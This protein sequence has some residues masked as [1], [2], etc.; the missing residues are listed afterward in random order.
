MTTLYVAINKDSR[1]IFFRF[2]FQ[3]YTKFWNAGE[4]MTVV[5]CVISSLWWFIFCPSF[6]YFIQTTKQKV[7]SSWLLLKHRT[8]TI[9][10]REQKSQNNREQRSEQYQF[11]SNVRG[12]RCRSCRWN[13]GGLKTV[14]FAQLL[15]LSC[16]VDVWRIT[17]GHVADDGGLQALNNIPEVITRDKNIGW[18]WLIFLWEP[19]SFFLS[20]SYSA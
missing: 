6:H 17:R 14:L 10:Q 3:V 16:L 4:A 18:C 8:E 1:H 12:R 5:S 19:L 11:P 9:K 7:N 13:D 15:H 20:S 2:H